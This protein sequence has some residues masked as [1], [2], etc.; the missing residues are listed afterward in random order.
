MKPLNPKIYTK[1]YYLTDCS[2]F[3]EFKKT[4]G[5]SLGSKLKHVLSF[6]KIKKGMKVLDIGCGRGEVAFWA[7]RQGAEVIGIDYSEAG[8]KIANN[9][10]KKQ[11][12][13]IQKKVKFYVQNA[14]EI[15]F[16]ANSFNA[17][18]LI[19]VLEHLYPEEQDIVLKKSHQVLKT[20]GSLFAHTEP[21][22]IYID[23]TYP[24]W[25]YPMSTTVL[26]LWKYLTGKKLPTLLHPSMLRTEA[27]KIMHVNEPTYLRL[28]TIFQK[29]GFNARVI[30]KIVAL[31][32]VLSLKDWF[33]N[34]FVYLYPFSRYFPLNTLF[35]NDFVVI[36]KK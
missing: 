9:A 19:D 21:N 32:E 36:A 1:E 2:D 17:I 15:N 30:T 8:I 4:F 26:S 35:A 27:H 13:S 31:R 3:S 33:Y 18:F 25:C 23:Y 11:P 22:R 16:P 20:G 5:K 7:A 34:L 24:Y 14:K 28:K 12:K 29:F 6:F 10:L